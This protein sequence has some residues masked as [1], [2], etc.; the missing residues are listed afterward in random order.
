MEMFPFRRP[1]LRQVAA[2][3]VAPLPGVRLGRGAHHPRSAAWRSGAL[4]DRPGLGADRPL[5]PVVEGWLLLPPVAGLTL[6]FAVLRKELAL[7]LLIAFA[8]V[9]RRRRGGQHLVVHDDQP[10]RDLR[11]RQLALHPVRRDDR[12]AGPGAG[13]AAH[14]AHLAGTIVLALLVGGIVAR[15]VPLLGADGRPQSPVSRRSPSTQ[16]IV[17]RATSAERP[18]PW[19]PPSSSAMKRV[20]GART[21]ASRSLW[22][23]GTASSSLACASSTRGRPRAAADQ[24]EQLEERPQ[25]GGVEAAGV[26][27]ALRAARRGAGSSLELG[28]A[29]RAARRRRRGRAAPAS[30]RGRAA[31]APPAAASSRPCWCRGRRATARRTRRA[32]VRRRR[33]RPASRP[34]SMAPSLSPWPRKSKSSAAR[35]AAAACSPMSAWFSLRLPAPWHT[36]RRPAAAGGQEQQRRQRAG[37]PTRTPAARAG[38]GG[39]GLTGAWPPCARRRLRERGSR[40]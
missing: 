1:V 21:A 22:A 37:H 25:G 10:D 20:G 29:R 38:G 17:A 19:W 13:L 12:G 35:P 7:Q 33:R 32:A 9:R 34:A 15:V 31:R 16:A 28:R 26:L 2:Q 11:D 6:V 4:R 3:D 24:V 30:G 8:A 40:L 39:C 36:S 18:G 27:A 14:G 5:A 23:K